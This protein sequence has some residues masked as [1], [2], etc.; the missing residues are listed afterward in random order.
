MGRVMSRKMGKAIKAIRDRVHDKRVTECVPMITFL[1]ENIGVKATAE[2]IGGVT[3]GYVYGLL[4]G[5]EAPTQ[6]RLQKI[7]DVWEAHND[8]KK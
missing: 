5:K 8:N 2:E 6:E 7:K 1:V 3:T 4:S